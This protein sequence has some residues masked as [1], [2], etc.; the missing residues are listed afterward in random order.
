MEPHLRPK[1]ILLLAGNELFLLEQ[2][3]W[4]RG[5]YLE[6]NLEALITEATANRNANYYAL[7]YFLIGKETLSPDGEMVLLDQLDED[8]HKSAYEVT[9]D[10]KEGIIHAVEDLAN[11]ALFYLKDKLNE[12]FDE[13][14]DQFEM[15]IRDDCLRIIY[16]LLFIF[17]AESREELD[18]LPGNDP[19]YV[20]GHSLEMLR[21]LEQVPLYSENSLNG[22][23]FHDS[24]SKLFRV[25]SSGYREKENG[26]NKSFKVRHIDSPIFDNRKL[27]HLHRVK[28]RNKVW[29]DIICR[30][31]LSK[32]QRNR[33]RGRIS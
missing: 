22:Y 30:L 16:R 8:S 9:K 13:T 20:R 31:S 12:E 33:A 14:D 27:N 18:I 6:F 19:V 4:F 15:E 32:Q 17:Y 10:L 7:F 1:Y 2:E 3:K 29:Q 21:D 28:F 24:L 23:F 26:D 25:L 11:E 5:S